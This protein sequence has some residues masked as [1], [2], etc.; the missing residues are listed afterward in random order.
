VPLPGSGTSSQNAC[1]FAVREL[2]LVTCERESAHPPIQ[3][4]VQD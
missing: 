1:T 3:S 4:N 2:Y